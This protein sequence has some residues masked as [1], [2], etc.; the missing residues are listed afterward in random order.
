MDDGQ[1]SANSRARAVQ[2]VWEEDAQS[3][4]E[5]WRLNCA[6]TDGVSESQCTPNHNGKVA[7]LLDGV[8]GTRKGLVKA[9][10]PRKLKIS[11]PSTAITIPAQ[12]GAA[13]RT[14][15][16]N[17]NPIWDVHPLKLVTETMVHLVATWQ[18]APHR[19]R[20]EIIED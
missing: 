3:I 13:G 20:T 6:N 15:F 1:I 8:Q 5:H 14:L 16:P 17:V 19:V 4:V 7:L 12:K 9:S 2:R 10:S 18:R 11:G